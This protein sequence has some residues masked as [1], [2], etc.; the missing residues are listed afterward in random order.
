M[1]FKL[2]APLFSPALHIVTQQPE[3]LFPQLGLFDP[4]LIFQAKSRLQFL[5]KLELRRV[6]LRQR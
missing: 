2:E 3:Q 1:A 5:P 6:E 4:N